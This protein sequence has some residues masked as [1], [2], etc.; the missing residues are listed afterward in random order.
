MI[1]FFIYYSMFGFQRI[2]DLAWAAGDLRVRGFLLGATAGRT[3]LAGEGL[4]HDDGQSH[5][6]SSVIPNCI[7]YD[8]TYAYELAVIIQNGLY[9]MFEKQEDVYFYIT[10]MNENYIQPSIP[11]AVED[12]ILKGMYLLRSSDVEAETHVQ[13]MGSGT[14]LREVELAAEILEKEFFVTSDIWS[15]T[16]FTELSRDGNEI[17]R[18]NKL[19][20]KSTQ[21]TPYIAKCLEDKKGPVIAATDY[22]RLVADQ[23]RQYVSSPY[24][25][26]GT[27]GFGRSDTRKKLRHHFEV[28]AKMIAYT[29]LRA[30]ANQG[31]YE[32]G[33]LSDAINKLG[34]ETGKS[35]PFLS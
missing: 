35:D 16:S 31:G 12:G 29:A 30:L 32:A 11:K 18:F 3:T 6:F 34:I 23:V 22:V 20:P 4:Q 9:R 26:L 10:V 7:S 2:G 28:D 25:V 33:K 13:L 27:D 5:L 8:P 21:G 17:S 14:I 1:P 19:N 24:Y 15:V